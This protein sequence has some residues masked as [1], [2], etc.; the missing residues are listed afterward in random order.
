MLGNTENHTQRNLYANYIGTLVQVAGPIISL[1]YYLSLLGPFQFGLVSV[2]ATIQATL[3]LLEAGFAQV[4]AKEFAVLTNKANPDYA[5]V[6]YY[7]KGF[8]KIFWGISITL[9]LATACMSGFLADHWLLAS[10][11]SGKKLSADAI[12]GAALIF[13]VQFPSSLYRSY[14]V[15]SQQQEK[16]NIICSTGVLVRHGGGIIVLW[17]HP[18]LHTYLVWQVLSHG[19][20][21]WVRSSVSWRS[22]AYLPIPAIEKKKRFAIVIRDSLRMFV[23]VLLGTVTTQLD[24]IILSG[25]LPL[26]Q[27]GYYSIASTV[28]IG[29]IVAIQPIVQAISPLMM[30]SADN[31]EA[32]RLQCIKLAKIISIVVIAIA[33]G[34]LLFGHIMLALWLRNG[35]A[36]NYIFPILS[37]LLVGSGLNAYYHIGYYNWLA[38][39]KT[40]MIFMVNLVAFIL[41]ISVTP[42]L[43]KME[44]AMGATFGFVVMNLLGLMLSIG[45]VRKSTDLKCTKI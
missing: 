1:P 31:K 3:G 19:V 2:I 11:E 18:T 4:S 35:Q 14:L 13:A 15:G 8:E 39:G 38:R 7:L 9:G 27:F 25:A 41:T 6:A 32:L 29:V 5:S 24:K 26:E 21:T 36:V 28:S 20:E 17:I 10:T 33:V 45:W 42:T 30:Q 22:V 43:I 12:I 34:Y 16:M 37:V 23:A 40:R 44:G